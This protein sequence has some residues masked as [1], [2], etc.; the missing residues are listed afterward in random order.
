MK[1]QEL[2]E[3]SVD[4]LN[5]ELLRL[6]REEFVLRMQVASGQIGQSHMVK[7]LRRDVARVKT[8]MKEKAND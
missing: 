2:R 4:E 3:K 1:A 7:E 5:V 8:L 6:R